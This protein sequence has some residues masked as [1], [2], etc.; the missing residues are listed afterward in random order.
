MWS[1]GSGRSQIRGLALG[2][3]AL[4]GVAAAGIV[5]A[6]GAYP[7]DQPRLRSGAAWLAS[8]QVGQ[9]TLLD[10]SSAEVAAQVG[11]APPGNQLDVVQQGS[12]AYSVDRTA[13][14][15]RRVD[16]STFEP[17]PAAQPLA[18]ARDGLRAYAGPDV[19]YLLDTRRGVLT[20]ADPHTLVAQGRPVSL[21]ARVSPQ[22]A[23]LDEAGRLWVLD[24]DSGDLV[25]LR[26]GTRHSR[27]VGTGGTAQLTVAGGV[28]VVVDPEHR[29]ATT[30]DPVS[31]APRRTF[32]LDLR[33]GDRVQVS[34]AA[35]DPRLY[36][37][38][39]RGVLAICDLAG[40]GC[41]VTVPIGTQTSDFGAP[42][43]AGGRLF[44]P[45]YA[46][47]QVWVVDLD[48]G[49]VLARPRVLSPATRR[50]G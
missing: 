19:L 32:P 13:G 29:T 36:L 43:E 26:D 1:A 4:C 10:G 22:A 16:G 30:F 45:D 18:D 38:A 39:A 47:G 31:G 23:S 9:L 20:G 3:I 40:A 41:G 46:T 7:A 44:V 33:S 6:R 11:V 25:W 2:V 14:T 49:K 5:G 28:P 48:T 42:V 34:G 24:A 50:T 17:T 15:I 37:V 35:H 27:H 21:S 8:T 12:V